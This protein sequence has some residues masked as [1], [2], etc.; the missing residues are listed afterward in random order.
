MGEQLLSDL[1]RTN[2]FLVLAAGKGD[3]KAVKQHLND[4][5]NVNARIPPPLG[6]LN[7]KQDEVR[8]NPEPGWLLISSSLEGLVKV[9][10]ANCERTALQAAADGGFKDVVELLL[11]Y[12]ADVNAPPATVFGRTALQAAAGSGNLDIV[13]ILV[14][15]ANA[16]VNALPAEQYGRTALQAAAEGGHLEV[17]RFLINY[18]AK[19]DSAPGEKF[20]RTALQAAAGA[21]WVDVVDLLLTKERFLVN[22]DNEDPAEIG[23]RTAIQ[24]AA[25]GGHER[26]VEMLIAAG[27]DVSAQPAAN[28]GTTALEAA[29]H[30]GHEK[31]LRQLFDAGVFIGAGPSCT[32]LHDAVDDEGRLRM[33]L[34][35]S[36]FHVNEKDHLGS[37]PLHTAVKKT[38]VESV[39][40]LIDAGADPDIVDISGATPL[41][42]ALEKGSEEILNLL[43]H[44]GAGTD[45]LKVDRYVDLIKASHI[46]KQYDERAI[47]LREVLPQRRAVETVPWESTE[48]KDLKDESW[49]SPSICLFK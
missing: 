38:K 41:Q 3:K 8:G 25:A 9:E 29:A 21:G 28:Y 6:K 48:I 2:Y 13:E 27:A 45:Q 18:S 43:L 44:N 10:M 4:G 1:D 12:K 22:S 32:I 36:K 7:N 26:V 40:L 31:V 24:A 39:R 11:D 20:G 19:I 35:L 34:R 42:T 17:V 5:A 37:T 49:S 15:E 14:L 16:N 30:G 33:L 23:G 47:I 46:T